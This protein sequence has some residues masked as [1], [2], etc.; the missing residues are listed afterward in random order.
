[1][2]THFQGMINLFA[3]NDCNREPRVAFRNFFAGIFYPGFSIPCY[4][5]MVVASIGF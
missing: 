3:E 5:Y 2:R 1:M 4:L